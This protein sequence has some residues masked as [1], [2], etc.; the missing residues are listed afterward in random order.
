MRKDVRSFSLVDTSYGYKQTGYTNWPILA[1]FFFSCLVLMG[2][3]F[4]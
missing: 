3:I 1:M 4:R 2:I